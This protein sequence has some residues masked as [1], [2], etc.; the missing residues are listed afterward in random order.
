MDKKKEINIM[1]SCDENL[2]GQIPILLRSI[3]ESLKDRKIR[4][5]FLFHNISE[6]TLDLLERQCTFY[7]NIDFCRIRIDLNEME[8]FRILASAGGQWCPEAYFSLMA[9]EL[10][11]TDAERVLYLDAGDTLVVGNIDKYY[12]MDFEENFIIATGICYKEINNQ[13][14]SIDEEDIEDPVGL[15]AVTRGLFNSGSYIMNLV[16]MRE[17]GRYTLS[18]YLELA[19][20]TKQLR[21][22]EQAYWGDQGFLST[23]FVGKIKYY[24]YPEIRDYWYMPY[25]FCLWYYDSRT[26]KP[27]YDISIIHFAGAVKPWKVSYPTYLR[28][29]QSEE[30]LGM[31][32]LK[33]CQV[34][35]YLVW[36]D[37]A[38]KTEV[39][40]EQLE[41]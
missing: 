14:Y 6:L 40:I 21:G 35:Y 13:L 29:F 15:A 41:S 1:T 24:A 32:N 7:G 19:S 26:E 33:K 25:N 9:H 16:K 11:P 22:M 37:I 20:L 34:P 30:L 28:R 17:D 31:E 39:L 3:A 18:A 4:F 5:F 12:Y 36:Y 27:G 2:V 23:V 10:L 8:I 38:Q